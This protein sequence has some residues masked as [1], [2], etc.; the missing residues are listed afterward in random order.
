MLERCLYQRYENPIIRGF[1]PDPSICRVGEDYYLVTSSFEYFPGLPIYHSK[2]L[3]NWKQIGNCLQR[4]EEFPLNHVKD[5]GGIW[6]PTIRYCEGVF[7][8]TA[9]LEQY[10]NFIVHTE[11]PA[12]RWSAPVW[13]AVGGIDP[14][15][16]F[17][18]EKIYFC[19][20]EREHSEREEITLEEIDIATGAL[21]TKPKAIWTGVGGGFLE[22][23]HIYHI[24]EWYYIVA[25]EGGTNYNHMV[26]VGRSKDIWGPYENC[27]WNPV[28]TNVHD[29]SK[30]VQCSGH[31]DLLEDHNGNWWMVHLGIRL[32]RRTMTNLGRETFLTPIKWQDGWPVVENDKKASLRAAGPLWA[33]QREVTAWAAD[34]NNSE[35][36]P[37]VIFLRSPVA[38]NYSR[39]G[40]LLRITPSITSLNDC[41]NPSFVARRPFDFDC[42]MDVE[43]TFLPE[44]DGDEAGVAV[45]LSAD[46]HV[47]LA[48]RREQGKNYLLLQ[49]IAEDIN[50]IVYREELQYE[51]TEKLRM[52]IR[53]DK[54][55]Y[56]FF[57]GANDEMVLVRTASTRFLCCEIAGKCFTGTIWGIYTRC[58]CKTDARL[59][60]NRW[61]M[62][63]L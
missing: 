6:A 54:E 41:A 4:A 52:V 8:V 10:G 42:E 45:M 1:N 33:V 32:C 57:Y 39:G 63:K 53:A 24:G 22:A 46:F 5:S 40:G 61:G 35:W 3:V 60:V 48:I 7:Y 59:Y 43:I 26:T 51:A 34:F 56:S 13:V 15:L 31:G 12:G 2:D 14:S 11:N 44:R 18:G 28:L 29:T 20:N 50:Q 21:L 58:D 49:R 17:E 9:T 16:L 19:T 62:K 25:A 27:P 38:E 30:E 47:E 37:E 23:P 36:E 55:K